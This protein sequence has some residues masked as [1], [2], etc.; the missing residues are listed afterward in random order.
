MIVRSNPPTLAL[1]GVLLL[2][3][4]LAGVVIAGLSRDAARPVVPAGKAAHPEVMR[5]GVF[6]PP[7]AAPEFS[8]RGSDGSEVTLARYRGKVVLLTFGFTYCATVCPTT[9]ATLAQARAKLGKAADSVRVIFVTVDPARDD[10]AHLREFLAA[11]D[12]SF[13]GATA[14]PDA[15]AAVRQKY[16]VT[17][18][19]HGT[20]DDYVMAHTSSIFLIDRAGKLRALMPFGHDAADFV[21]DV[22][23]LLAA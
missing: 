2:S 16:G 3:L 4:L 20:G 5:A 12:P 14:A 6:D 8:L 10:A 7:H 19:R 23:A 11:F 13:V 1:A 17:A 21:H 9:M 15:L 18:V 22:K